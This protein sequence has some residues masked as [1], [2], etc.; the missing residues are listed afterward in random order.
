MR[1]PAASVARFG[2]AA[3]VLVSAYSCASSTP[4]SPSPT[5]TTTTTT[6]PTS[7]A[8]T[9]ALAP[10]CAGVIEGSG[11]DVFLDGV[12]VGV[13][14][15]TQPFVKTVPIGTHTIRGRDRGGFSPETTIDIKAAQFVFAI[16]C[17]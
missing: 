17:G 5:T 2:I 13:A 14:T 3:L 9:V 12:L 10:N 7:S 1:L 6:V 4:S 16:G 15:Q 8:L 11:L